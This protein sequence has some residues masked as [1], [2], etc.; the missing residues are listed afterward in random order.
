MQ[1]ERFKHSFVPL[2]TVT[3]GVSKLVICMNV[4]YNLCAV[5][6][7]WFYCLMYIS[8]RC[9]MYVTHHTSHHEEYGGILYEA[10]LAF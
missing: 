2:A 10:I 8:Q 1:A 3:L 9:I 6:I 5:F 7:E 4:L